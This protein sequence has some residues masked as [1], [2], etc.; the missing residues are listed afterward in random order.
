MSKKYALISVS[1]K[2]DIVP[3]AEAI[4]K[5]G[6]E[7]I[8]TGGTA[9]EL[10]KSNIKITP[11]QKIT[12]N[13]ESFDGRMKT[14]S[15]QIESALLY[16]RSNAK[17]VAEAKQLKIPQ[18][19]I[20][21]CNLYPFEK[22]VAD[23]KVSYKTA[24]E[25]IDVG[26]PT[27]IRAAAKNG[28]IVVTDPSDYQTVTDALPK[29]IDMKL[30][31][32]LQAKAFDHLTFYDSQIAWYLR[33]QM[34]ETIFPQEITIPGR[35]L[36]DLRYGENPHQKGAVYTRPNVAT[37][38]NH[39]TKHWGRDLSLVNVTDI[40]AGLDVVRLFDQPAAAVIKHN[41]PCGAALGN[42]LDEALSNAIEGDPES[43]FGGIIVLNKPMDLAAAKV[44][45]G[46]KDAKRG[47]MD[48]IA[49]PSIKPN[50]LAFLQKVRKSMGIYSFGDIPS[51][52]DEWNLKSIDGGFV[53]QT[54]D[55]DIDESFKQWQVVTKKKPTKQQLEQMQIGWKFITKIK[56]NTVLVMDKTIPMTRG[57]G[58]GQTSRVRSTKIAIEQAGKYTKDGILV[59][60][61]FFPFGDSV[62]LAVK[63]G[64]AAVVQQ[65]GSV[66][67][68]QSIDAADKAGIPMIFT[69]RRAFWH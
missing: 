8:S 7:I 65:G 30:L 64:I 68:Q 34:D 5:A 67:D 25:N 69:G 36:I 53:L 11:I 13:P 43:A 48:I 66:N 26:G 47:N 1:D 45:G 51:L 29:K 3:F 61:S 27:M 46:F 10:E 41:S 14:I 42:T 15:F 18:I 52:S 60:D 54:A 59:G 19:D 24:I 50:A 37:P 33:S 32:Y 35:K 2:T 44:I 12:G 39:L 57:I 16:D 31:R 55:I 56:S 9:K 28:L 22:T 40:N 6:Y 17:H 63:H 58:S 38:F 23:K 49:V 21:V 4:I 20:V 62:E